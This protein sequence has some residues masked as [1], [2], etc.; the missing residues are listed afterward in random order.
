MVS[1]DGATLCWRIGRTAGP[2]FNCN[3]DY[4]VSYTWEMACINTGALSEYCSLRLWDISDRWSR[5]H[6]PRLTSSSIASIGTRDAGSGTAAGV[7]TLNAYFQSF[8][9]SS[10]C[11]LRKFF[12]SSVSPFCLSYISSIHRFNTA[13]RTRAS[14]ISYTLIRSIAC[15][16][17]CWYR[18]PQFRW[19]TFIL[20][21]L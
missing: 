9:F 3:A 5:S 6:L 10:H 12:I 8:V 11:F 4:N 18:W 19:H 1:R 21:V 17:S 13:S 16:T 15:L 14:S 7:S 2:D 20:S